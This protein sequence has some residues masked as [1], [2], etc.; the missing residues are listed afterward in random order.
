MSS[1]EEGAYARIHALPQGDDALTTGE[2][3]RLRAEARQEAAA[4]RKAQAKRAAEAEAQEEAASVKKRPAAQV[5]KRP[6][7]EVR[8]RPAAEVR[9]E[10]ASVVKKRPAQGSG[11]SAQETEDSHNGSYQEPPKDQRLQAPRLLFKRQARAQARARF[12]AGVGLSHFQRALYG[13]R[14]P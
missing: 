10:A 6:A 3:R 8:K 1:S 11:S 5:R 13:I 2:L 9:Y 7:A 12:D 4:A 14:R